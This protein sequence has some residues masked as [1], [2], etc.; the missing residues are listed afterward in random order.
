MYVLTTMKF[1][2]K[3]KQLFSVSVSV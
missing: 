3:S 2:Y 1:M